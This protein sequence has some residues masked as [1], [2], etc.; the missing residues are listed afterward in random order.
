[1]P[2]EVGLAVVEPLAAPPVA[3]PPVLGSWVTGTLQFQ[4]RVIVL[5]R[6]IAE[7][8]AEVTEQVGM[9]VQEFEFLLQVP[10][11]QV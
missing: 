2:L 4:V 3:K 6:L 1:M 11:L 5:P 10:L 9:R 8:L 7:G